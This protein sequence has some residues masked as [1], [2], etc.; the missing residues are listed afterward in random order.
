MTAPSYATCDQHC[1]DLINDLQVQ[2]VC[3]YESNPNDRIITL[4]DIQNGTCTAFEQ[5]DRFGGQYQV[6]QKNTVVAKHQK[7]FWDTTF[8][9]EKHR[10]HVSRENILSTFEYAH[11]RWVSEDT[12][13]LWNVDSESYL[14]TLGLD[15]LNLLLKYEDTCFPPADDPRGTVVALTFVAQGQLRHVK[16][17]V[18]SDGKKWGPVLEE[19]KLNLS[20]KELACLQ[21][22]KIKNAIDKATA[23][24]KSKMIFSPIDICA[25]VKQFSG[26][27]TCVDNSIVYGQSNS[28][29]RMMFVLY[30]VT[31]KRTAE[32]V[33]SVYRKPVSPR[34]ALNL[35]ELSEFSEPQQRLFRCYAAQLN[36]WSRNQDLL[37][38]WHCNGGSHREDSTNGVRQA[39]NLKL[40]QSHQLCTHNDGS[41]D[42]CRIEMGK[43]HI[44][45]E[46]G[47]Y[48]PRAR[49]VPKRVHP[50]LAQ[51]LFLANGHGHETEDE[52]ASQT[53]EIESEDVSSESP[54]PATTPEPQENTRK[55]AC[56]DGEIQSNNPKR[57]CIDT[58]ETGTDET[59]DEGSWWNWKYWKYWKE[60][61]VRRLDTTEKLVETHT[62]RHDVTEMHVTELRQQVLEL[63]AQVDERNQPSSTTTSIPT[64]PSAVAR[65]YMHLIKECYGLA[66]SIDGRELKDREDRNV[67]RTLQKE[68]Y[69]VGKAHMEQVGSQKFVQASHVSTFI[70]RLKERFPVIYY[71]RQSYLPVIYQ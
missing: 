56:G 12:V 48:G 60:L 54:S 44:F 14:E 50:K 35:D 1:K 39:H 19:H 27:V 62:H 21:L 8:T 15:M 33:T 31:A 24:H 61:F 49:K 11:T 59:E 9:T 10:F 3:S 45:C 20:N 57:P 51:K 68:G 64:E 6:V 58:A 16:S 63:Q 32:S 71:D 55:R 4:D 36:E 52:P 38:E 5:S 34:L 66:L 43:A 23:R 28:R 53:P 17:Y 40:F 13:R 65:P 30:R 42:G 2:A 41:R 46:R 37:Q 25:D 18:N 29:N 22:K 67:C 70:S 26:K 69:L 47:G 7:K